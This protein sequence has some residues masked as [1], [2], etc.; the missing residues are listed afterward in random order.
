[1]RDLGLRWLVGCAQ[2]LK[3]C[4]GED[5]APAKGVERAIALQNAHPP[6]GKAPLDQNAEIETGRP[7]AN[8][9][10]A[11]I[12]SGHLLTF[13]LERQTNPA[14]L[15]YP[16]SEASMKVR[17]LR[18]ISF[19]LC[20]AGG[21]A[22]I[23]YAAHPASATA[24]VTL[25]S[26]FDGSRSTIPVTINGQR[27]SCTLDTGTSVLLVSSAVAAQAGLDA[28]AGTFEVA[29][30]GHTYVDRQTQIDRFGVAGST[31]HNVPALISSN[32]S[33]ENA[34]CGYEFFTHFPALID[35]RHRLVTLFPASSRLA[36][37]HCI[38]VDLSP[39][40]PLATVE[41][42]GTWLDHVVLDSGM[43]GGGA[44]WQ[45]VRS[46]L[47]QPLVANAN[48]VT[49]PAAIREGLA[50]G[51]VA[52]VRYAPGS[53]LSSMPICTESQRPDGYNGII[54]TNLST[55]RA[56]AVDYPHH[57]ICFDVASYSPPAS[58]QLQRSLPYDA[59]ARFNHLRPPKKL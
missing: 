57:H 19:S 53:P 13:L 52:S 46:R 7:A 20:L 35:R 54:E 27:A 6:R 15:W 28:R 14:L 45:G 33:G 1:L 36:H 56:M 18:A 39:H 30:D 47:R 23:V 25:T 9:G 21:V 38:T 17:L 2:V 59:W 58:A 42:N 49:M 40:V 32:L 43:A 8:S 29:P 16:T 41:I 26:G 5:D 22:A 50:C 44:L 34:L 51:A 55:V 12:S 37:M 48:Y 24:S 10:D 3:R 4:V 11:H 31:L